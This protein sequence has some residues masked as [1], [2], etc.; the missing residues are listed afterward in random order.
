[1]KFRLKLFSLT[2][3][4]FLGFLKASFEGLAER[5]EG[6]YVHLLILTVVG[7]YVHLL[8]LVVVSLTAKF[9]LSVV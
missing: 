5:A 7:R 4:F 3:S 9:F 8:M 2:T 1:M 6:Q